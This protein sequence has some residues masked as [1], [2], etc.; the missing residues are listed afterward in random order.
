M[1]RLAIGFL[2]FIFLLPLLGLFGCGGK[3][4][5]PVTIN[6]SPGTVALTAGEKQQFTSGS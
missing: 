3:G 6:V 2:A 5:P 1:K 4:K